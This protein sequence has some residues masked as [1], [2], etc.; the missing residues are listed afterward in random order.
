MT[1]TFHEVLFPAAISYSST[2]GPKFKTT[3][4][5]ADSGFEQRNIDWQN[6]R[7]E[8]D[9]SHAIKSQVQMDELTNFFYARRGR[10]YGFRFKDWNDFQIK[11]QKIAEGDGIL[12]AFQIVKIYSSVQTE[13][14]EVDL[15]T[16]KIVKINWNTVAGVTVGG[17]VVTQT[18]DIVTGQAWSVNYNTGIITFVHPPDDGDDVV[19][20]AAEFHV[21]VRFDTDHLDVT[22]EF[23]ETASWPN[24][25]L[26]EVRDWGEALT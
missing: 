12:S 2:G 1:T 25:S 18:P 20:G 5:T 13:S 10:A 11:N 16:R 14:S 17:V 24:I 6:T 4:F 9:V 8:Y 3:I 15:Y 19:I 22:Q 7:A 26:I 23:W 21:P